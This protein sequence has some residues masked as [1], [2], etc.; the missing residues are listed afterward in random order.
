MFN[1][2]EMA[3]CKKDL[4]G[5]VINWD[6]GSWIVTDQVR[7]EEA[8]LGDFCEPDI[9]IVDITYCNYKGSKILHYIRE[10]IK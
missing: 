7:L 9:L 5:N 10:K 8:T 1:Y 6:R 2:S 4:S 3:T